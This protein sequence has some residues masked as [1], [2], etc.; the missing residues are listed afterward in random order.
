MSQ[1]ES[2]SPVEI[3]EFTHFLSLGLLDMAQVRTEDAS[4]Y[5]DTIQNCF[6]GAVKVWLDSVFTTPELRAAVL[7]SLSFDKILGGLA[8]RVRLSGMQYFLLEQCG[9]SLFG[10]LVEQQLEIEGRNR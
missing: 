2:P 4:V 6:S 8:M 7:R 10:Y 9:R 1:L 5:L 3:A